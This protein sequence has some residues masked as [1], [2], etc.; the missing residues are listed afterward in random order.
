MGLATEAARTVIEYAKEAFPEKS[1]YA[2]HNPHNKASQRVLEKL[3]FSFLGLELYIQTGL[4]HP[5]YILR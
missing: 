2:G 4:M 3:G 5:T 1:I